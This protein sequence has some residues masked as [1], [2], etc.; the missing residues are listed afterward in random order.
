MKTAFYEFSQNNSGGSFDVDE[1]VCHR[2]VIE[3]TSEDHARDILEPM[4][5]GQSASCPCCGDRW[6]PYYAD[7]LNIEKF[8]E[9]GYGVGVYSHYADAEKRWFDLYGNLPRLTEPEWTDEYGSRKFLGKVYFDTIEQYCQFMADTY[10]WT[11]P[12]VRIFRLDGTK[13]EIFKKA[14][15]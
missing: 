8:K 14:L 12:D 6:T 1:N 13:T 15:D 7:E 4:I 3:A 5:A 10:G 9:S 2:V 11:T